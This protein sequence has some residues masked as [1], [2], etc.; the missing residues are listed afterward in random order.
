MAGSWMMTFG[1]CT[2]VQAEDQVVQHLS[3]VFKSVPVMEI[4]RK[5][6]FK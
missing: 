1:I 2:L 3:T 5:K 4:V 6:Y